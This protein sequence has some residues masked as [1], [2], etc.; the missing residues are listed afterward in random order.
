MTFKLPSSSKNPSPERD[1]SFIWWDERLKKQIQCH[2]NDENKK[3][4]VSVDK[5]LLFMKKILQVNDDTE[6]WN[7]FAPFHDFCQKFTFIFAQEVVVRGHIRS[8]L[9]IGNTWWNV[10]VCTS[11][12]FNLVRLQCLLLALYL[13]LEIISNVESF[14]GPWST[15]IIKGTMEN[16]IFNVAF[17]RIASYSW[18]ETQRVQKMHK[19]HVLFWN[20]DKTRENATISCSVTLGFREKLSNS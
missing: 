17:L 11:Y 16:P 6:P 3:K 12:N 2:T 10:F 7:Y 5:L 9:Y 15:M 14:G 1:R 8:T 19:T 13:K 4:S 20:T 18:V